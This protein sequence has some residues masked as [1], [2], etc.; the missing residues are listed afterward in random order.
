VRGFDVGSR[1]QTSTKRA[2]RIDAAAATARRL[3][4]PGEGAQT[5]ACGDGCGFGSVGCLLRAAEELLQRGRDR[6]REDTVDE[7][8]SAACAVGDEI[9]HRRRASVG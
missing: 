4:L 2:L 5:D 7:A 9:G 6:G 3:F 1:Y 8:G